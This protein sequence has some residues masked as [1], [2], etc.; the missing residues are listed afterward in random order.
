MVVAVVAV[1]VVIRGHDTQRAGVADR[2]AERVQIH[3]L[4]LAPRGR[5]V[6]AGV[7]VAAALRDAVDGEMLRRGDDAIF[8]DATHLL[9]AQLANQ[10]RILAVGLDR[11]APARIAP[12]R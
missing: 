6:G 1:V 10:E 2:A 7:A 8:L 3:R 12:T 4:D 5:R 11:A 9:E